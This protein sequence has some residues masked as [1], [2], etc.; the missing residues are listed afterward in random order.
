[1]PRLYGEGERGG[2][3]HRELTVRVVG[4]APSYR[5]ESSCLPSPNAQLKLAPELQARGG[6]R[7]PLA[8]QR[9]GEAFDLSKGIIERAAYLASEGARDERSLLHTCSPA[10]GA[11]LLHWLLLGSAAASDAGNTAKGADDTGRRPKV[12]ALLQTLAAAC[13]SALLAQPIT[14]RVTAP[15]KVFGDIH[16]QFADLLLLLGNFGFPSHKS[17]DVQTTSYVFDGDWI[18]RGPH[19]LE[20]RAARVCVRGEQRARAW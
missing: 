7:G 18:D 1:M 9:G 13:A 3:V 17:G 20:V 11:V 14:V 5:G 12:H 15:A 19:Q 16:G 10:R 2:G 8:A 6:W 4:E